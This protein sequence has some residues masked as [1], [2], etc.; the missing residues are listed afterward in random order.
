MKEKQ[1][2]NLGLT[3]MQSIINWLI[4]LFK[5]PIFKN[6]ECK[7][8]MLFTYIKQNN[9]LIGFKLIVLQ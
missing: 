2:I 4:I 1:I 8:N 5:M 6:G 3:Y 7:K 9:N